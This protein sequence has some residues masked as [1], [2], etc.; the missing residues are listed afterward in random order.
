[1][2]DAVRAAAGHRHRVGQAG[3]LGRGGDRLGRRDADLLAAVVAPG[4]HGA[5]IQDGHAVEFARPD[6]DRT[7]DIGHLRRSRDTVAGRA[8]ETAVAELTVRVDAPGVDGA[9]VRQ[10]QA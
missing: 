1:Q 3:D 2:D 8:G 7:G 6:G 10:G 9:V 4:P 5:V